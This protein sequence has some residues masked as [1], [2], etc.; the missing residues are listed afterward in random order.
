MGGDKRR[1]M[2]KTKISWY[3]VSTKCF[4]YKY[5]KESTIIILFVFSD[6]YNKV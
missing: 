1:R 5:T 4:T 2:I 3:V 6:E